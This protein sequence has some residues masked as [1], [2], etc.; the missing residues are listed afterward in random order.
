MIGVLTDDAQSLSSAVF[1]QV[2]MSFVLSTVQIPVVRIAQ[3]GNCPISYK[4]NLRVC[5]AISR[6][7]VFVSAAHAQTLV[8][9]TIIICLSDTWVVGQNQIPPNLVSDFTSLSSE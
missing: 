4:P 1:V 9:L 7:G 5:D 2:I 3:S 8:C 6:V